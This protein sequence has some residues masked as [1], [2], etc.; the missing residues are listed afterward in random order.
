MLDTL[1]GEMVGFAITT[2]VLSRIS[3][4]GATSI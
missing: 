2:P 3:I 4:T 1:Y